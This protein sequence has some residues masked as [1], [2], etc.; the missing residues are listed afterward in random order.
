MDKKSKSIKSL[1]DIKETLYKQ[2]EL[3]VEDSQKTCESENLR[4]NT[5]TILKVYEVLISL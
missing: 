1:E 4:E 3:L 2:V 5:N